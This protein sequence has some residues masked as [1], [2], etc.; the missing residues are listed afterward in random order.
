MHV[1]SVVSECAPLIKTGGL[2]DVAGALPGA[3]ATQGVAMR[4]LMPA[5]R[6][7]ADRLAAPRATKLDTPF[8]PVRLLE[9]E[10]AGLELILI[11]APALYDRPGGPYA[12]PDRADWP[13]NALRFGLL[14]WMGA[15]IATQ[16]LRGW[17]PDAVHAHDWQAGLTP[18]YLRLAGPEAPRA[19]I[20]IHNIAFQGL[21][22][23]ETLAPLALPEAMFHPDHLEFHGHVGFLKAGLA[24]AERITTVSPTYARELLT[25]AFGYGLD[26]LLRHRA[27]ALEGVLNGIDAD[28][29]NPATDPDIARPYRAAAGKRPNR[30]ALAT[31]MG[32]NPPP[33]APLFC[34]IS[35][36]TR[37]KGLDLL[38]DAMPALLAEGASLAV[39]GSGDADLEA[40]FAALAK[41]HPDRV[42]CVIGYD[43]PLAHQLQAGADAILVPSRFEPC[44][45]TQLCA[46]RYGTAP[47]VARTGGLADTVID[48]N[49]AALRVG[50][51]TGFVHAPGDA[52][53]LTDAIR[54]AC[55]LFRDRDAWRGLVRAALRQPVDWGESAARYADIYRRLAPGAAA[56]PA[57]APRQ[58]TS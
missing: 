14:G 22:G 43:E 30:R 57:A 21:F 52:A 50:A 34:V 19:V 18:T 39:L 47:V 11:D 48:A 32:M 8:G 17:R 37:Q 42:G 31:R 24:H 45:L 28:V 51:A 49:A 46:L 27:G 40:G 1:L 20:T 5:Y 9:G 26:G 16:G 53:A 7:L 12:G 23:R 56:L 4:T 41:A 3:L 44:G 25:P 15:R 10:A 13:D 33:D 29:W 6:G 58:E 38:L 2:A 54:R 35:R 55:A 36:M